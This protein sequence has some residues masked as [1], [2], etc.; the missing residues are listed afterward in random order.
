MLMEIP[1]ILELTKPLL[2]YLFTVVFVVIGGS[3]GFGKGQTKKE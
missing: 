2:Q 3:L 1:D